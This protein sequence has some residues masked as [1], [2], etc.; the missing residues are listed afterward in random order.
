MSLRTWNDGEK[1]INVKEIIES[2]FKFLGSHISKNV[3]ALSTLEREVL[4]TD[5]LSEGL[6]VFDTD[7]KTWYEYT[8]GKWKPKPDDT[9]VYTLNISENSWDANVIY[10]PFSTHLIEYPCV[11]VYIAI[12]DSYDTVIGCGTID[13]QFNVT[14][15]TDMPFSGKVVIK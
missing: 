12:G 4:S 2:N 14:L 9:S 1:G 11:Q 8:N 15:S 7:F 6:I 5:Y 3:L 10:I 13:D